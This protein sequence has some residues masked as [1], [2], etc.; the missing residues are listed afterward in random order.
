MRRLFANM[1]LAAVIAGVLGMWVVPA[2]AGWHF[3]PP[4]CDT[5]TGVCVSLD[6]NYV[7]PR[8][9]NSISDSNWA[10]DNYPNTAT[11]INNTVSSL[12]NRFATKDITWHKGT[13]GSG[14]SFCL[15]Q[16]GTN[17]DLGF[18]GSGFDDQISSNGVTTGL[19]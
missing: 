5:T 19:C 16:G 10:G 12:R 17:N 2:V 11:T 14:D 9:V 1:G 8:A 6:D 18:L 13:S 7:V 4:V 15:P 3:S